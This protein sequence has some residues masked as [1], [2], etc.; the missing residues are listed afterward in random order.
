[1]ADPID[2][3][4]YPEVGG[5]SRTSTSGE[6]LSAGEAKRIKQRLV[7]ANNYYKDKFEA[8]Y[9]D[10]ENL[11]NGDHWNNRISRNEKRGRYRIVVNYLQHVV[12]TIVAST[13]HQNPKVTLQPQDKVG[14]EN[15]D[16]ST[17]ATNYYYRRTAA[18]R[19]TKRALKDCVV[20][21]FGAVM[22]GWVQQQE[23]EAEV[24]G[25]QSVEGEP[26]DPEQVSLMIEEGKDLAPPIPKVK[27]VKDEPFCK[28]LDPRQIRTSP[29]CD[30]VVDDMPWIGYVE[31]RELNDVKSDPRFASGAT[32]KLKGNTVSL[33]GYLSPDYR[34]AKDEDIPTDVK[35]VELWHYYEKRRRLHI[36]FSNEHDQ[37]LMVEKWYWK[38]ERYP[39]RMMFQPALENDFYP[40]RPML[41]QLEHM[42]YEINLARTQLA[43]HRARHNRKYKAVEGAI[44]ES[45]KK[46]LENGEDGAIVFLNASSTNGVLDPIQDAPIHAEVYESDKVAQHDLSVLSAVDQYGLGNVPSKRLT[47]SE[48][49]AIQSNGGPRQQAMRLAYEELCAGVA[50]DY[51]DLLQQWAQHTRELPIYDDQQSV[52][53]WEPWTRDEIQGEYH[54]QVFVGSTE[55]PDQQGKLKDLGYLIQALG[56]FAQ[57]GM[58]NMQPLL[59]QML[60]NVPGIHDVDAILQPPQPQGGDAMAQAMAGQA[61][62][63]VPP[64][65][66]G[67]SIPGGGPP[68]IPPEILQQLMQQGG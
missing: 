44:S 23:M 43:T 61:G 28:R 26:L 52:V 29:E 56:P 55:I 30:W 13:A 33:K 7:C 17:R 40:N 45:A 47:T 41:L 22:T 35:R 14:Q 66:A 64:E 42:Q 8:T 50:E 10:C 27:I 57:S 3:Y 54:F 39:I 65:A 36:V 63:Q 67:A 68:D 53:G 58:V 60:R 21:G 48:V 6:K 32:R 24:E 49:Q 20:F 2:Q 62:G 37:P 31:V 1:M 5:S 46:V 16:K 18:H 12:E 51:L 34:T 4:S 38:H 25:R 15:E 9:R 19:E 11:Y 59:E